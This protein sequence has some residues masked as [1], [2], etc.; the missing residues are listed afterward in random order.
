MPVTLQIVDH[1]A[2]SWAV[3]KATTPEELFARVCPENYPQSERIIQTSLTRRTLR[4][5][6]T[7]PSENGFVWAA[8]R[9]Y[10]DHHHLTLRPEDIWFAILTQ[11]SFHINGNSEK[12]RYFFVEHEG[13]K[14]LE[15]VDA[16]SM[17]YADFS[18]FAER[19]T[20]MIA[21]NVK[22]P[23]LR[24]WVMPSFSTT[25]TTDQV[26]ASVLFMGA[27]QKYFSYNWT[28]DC[29][30]PSV[31]LLGEVADY[32]NI[33]ARLDRIEQLGDEPTQ[34]AEMLRPIL[35]YMILSFGAPANPQVVNF[36]NKI[37][38]RNLV[39]SGMD[40]I[41]GWITAFCYWSPQG[42]AKPR[43]R[44]DIVL[45]GVPYPSVDFDDIPT[46]MAS[47]PVTVRDHGDEFKCTIL[48]GSF[49][50]QGFS[51]PE[52]VRGSSDDSSSVDSHAESA[53]LVNIRPLSGW[54]MYENKE[55]SDTDASESMETPENELKTWE[56]LRL[57]A[58]TG[59]TDRLDDPL[60]ATNFAGK[61]A[62]RS[63]A[64][65]RV[66]R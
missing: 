16:G 45:D 64:W 29:G 66:E 6:H 48:A 8:C 27:M 39:G 62:N 22:D 15:V 58:G 12:L 47:V 35:R 44:Q 43:F 23:G 30:I 32:E 61:R 50:I 26:V 4:E 46:G 28:L 10:S 41:S 38:T 54:L 13:S 3:P 31:T 24:D 7:S 33:L 40:Y 17:D 9:A 19:M 34:F 55:K 52:A 57:N 60:L 59:E 25:T 2:T 11:L 14:E 42:I 37:A 49:G 5:T 63:F 36:W 21:K 53:D 65:A 51:R 56:E 20:H 1:L 18:V